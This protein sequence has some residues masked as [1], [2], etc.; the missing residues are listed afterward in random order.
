[1]IEKA[2]QDTEPEAKEQAID[3]MY[4]F[5]SNRETAPAVAIAPNRAQR[6]AAMKTHN[7]A[8]YTR[9]RR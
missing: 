4:D 9:K 5:L 2:L 7:H 6:R 8:L 1:M 3:A